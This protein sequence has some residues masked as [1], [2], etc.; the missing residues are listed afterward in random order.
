[1]RLFLIFVLFTLWFSFAR[2][3]SS[4][5]QGKK[6]NNFWEKESNANNT[7]KTSLECL[8]YVTI[9]LNLL[10]LTSVSTD[11]LI[12][13]YSKTLKTLSEKK[14]VNLTDISNTDLKLKYGSSN[15]PVLTEYDQNFTLLVQTLNHIGKRLFELDDINN[16]IIVLEYA[17]NCGSDISSTYKL[18]AQLYQDTNQSDKIASLIQSAKG[19]N[20]LMKNSI[21]QFLEALK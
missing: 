7:R 20:S 9:P 6:L 10:D 3:R 21:I 18:L 13:E 4:F 16:A 2:K 8:D 19:L 12:L 11:H 5:L 15:L 1:M 14:I 17:V